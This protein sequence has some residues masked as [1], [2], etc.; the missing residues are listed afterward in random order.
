MIEPALCGFIQLGIGDIAEVVWGKVD[1]NTDWRNGTITVNLVKLPSLSGKATPSY[2][3]NFQISVRSNA[4]DRS[5]SVAN[6]IIK[7]FHLHS[8]MVGTYLIS[9]S[10]VRSNGV[11]YEEEDLV[12]VPIQ[13][14][15]K[16]TGI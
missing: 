12:Q 7:L 4:I 9:V 5:Q 11:L 3:D 16:Y 6:A 1:A 2:L 8:G 14:S 10:D 15:V 13:L